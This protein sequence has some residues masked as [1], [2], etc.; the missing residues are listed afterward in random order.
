M[1]RVRAPRGSKDIL[2]GT[3]PF[4][5]KLTRDRS[6]LVKHPDEQRTIAT[7]RHMFFVR[8]LTMRQIVEELA[9]MGIVNSSRPRVS[10]ITRARDPALRPHAAAR[11]RLTETRSPA[12]AQGAHAALPR[13]SD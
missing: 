11:G 1:M 13:G 7:V 10:A 4:G 2:F 9:S 6:K 12:W 3:P 5:W 8:R